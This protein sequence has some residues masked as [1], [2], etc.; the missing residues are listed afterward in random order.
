MDVFLILMSGIESYIGYSFPILLH[1]EMRAILYR[2]HKMS[3]SDPL[4]AK[5]S[6]C[7]VKFLVIL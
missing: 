7:L 6:S 1:D 4:R 5:A 2:R 3:C